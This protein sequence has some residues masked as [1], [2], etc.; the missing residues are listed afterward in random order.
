MT[1]ES[2]VRELN[3]HQVKQRKSLR[4]N[5]MNNSPNRIQRRRIN[6]ITTRTITRRSTRPYSIN[7]IHKRNMNQG[8]PTILP[9]PHQS[10]RSHRHN[11]L[12]LRNRRRSQRFQSIQRRLMQTR[13]NSNQKRMRHYISTNLLSITM[14]NIARPSRIMMLH[15][16]LQTKPERIRNRNQR[17]TTRMISIRSRIIKRILQHPPS[18]PTRPQMRRPMLIP[19]YISQS[20]TIR[21]RIPQRIKISRKHRRTP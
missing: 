10:I 19:K 20:G 8:L 6:R 12:K 3:I 17:I 11:S 1:P 13:P 9:R 21:P 7:R 2:I 4:T 15:C 18:S 5:R 16:R 14:T